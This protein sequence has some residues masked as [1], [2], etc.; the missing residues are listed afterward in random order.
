MSAFFFINYMSKFLFKTMAVVPHKYE[1][2]HFPHDTAK[3]YSNVA[4]DLFIRVDHLNVGLVMGKILLTPLGN[5]RRKSCRT[6][7]NLSSQWV[8]QLS[9]ARA[10]SKTAT[11][12]KQL[13]L[14]QSRQKHQQPNT[15]SFIRFWNFG[16]GYENTLCLF[17]LGP[18]FW[19]MRRF[20][21]GESRC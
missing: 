15:D 21:K 2:V 10:H 18:L 14:S 5:D 13:L 7:L 17:F 9:W 12:Q 16:T 3:N 19:A 8:L 20:A 4:R 6:A 11:H 1:S